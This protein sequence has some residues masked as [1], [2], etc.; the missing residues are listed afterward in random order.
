[1]QGFDLSTAAD[2]TARENDGTW[3]ELF[4]ADEELMT[5][6]DGQPVAMRVAGA[7]SQHYRDAERAMVEQQLRKQRKQM[8]AEQATRRTK[9]MIAA[10]VLEWR[11]IFANG[12]P[13][14]CTRANVLAVFD[15]APWI[16]AQVVAA[17]GDHARFFEAA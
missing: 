11:G 17:V 2:I 13:L 3:I 14:P 6:G 1:M 9:E 4:G 10:C 7:H 15:A 8:T 12:E 5:F 16:Y